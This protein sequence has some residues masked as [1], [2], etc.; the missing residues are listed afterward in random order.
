MS[1]VARGSDHATIPADASV[2]E[3]AR[4]MVD[5]AVGCLV[6]LDAKGR[7]CGILT[8]R[9]LSIR[10]VAEGRDPARTL[11]AKAMSAP[12]I[13]ARPGDPMDAILARM[14]QYG[15]RRVPLVSDGVLVGVVRLDDLLLEFGRELADLGTAVTKARGKSRARPAARRRRR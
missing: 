9:D 5:G 7:P 3:A 4:R 10:V 8:D 14:E 15:I 1:A 6:V 13:A 2:L 12:L 11:V